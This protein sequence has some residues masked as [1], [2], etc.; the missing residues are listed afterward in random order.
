V[1]PGGVLIDVKS[2]LDPK[3]LPPGRVAYWCL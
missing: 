1:N 2:A 3:T